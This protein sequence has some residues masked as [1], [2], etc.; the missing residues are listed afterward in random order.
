MSSISSIDT[1]FYPALVEGF[2]PKTLLPVPAVQTEEETGAY[3]Y[4]GGNA[5][6][7]E[8]EVDLSN[9][10]D[11]VKPE[12]LLVKT[13]QNVIESAQV[14]DNSMV[15]AMQNGYSVQDVCNIRLAEMAYKA[16]AY[17]FDVAN[18]ISTFTIDV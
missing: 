7:S 13:G 18:K 2:A 6:N 3:G 12:D 10:Y 9:Y 8:P 4:S 14:L 1:S 5:S 11:R 16:N 15:V 17:V